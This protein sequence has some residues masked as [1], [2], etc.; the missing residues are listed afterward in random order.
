MQG[1]IDNIVKPILDALIP[2]IYMDD[3]QVERVWA[4]KFE[5]DRPIPLLIAEN[6]TAALSSILDAEP[7]ALYI[8]ID[9]DVSLGT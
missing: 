2:F 3:S 6:P 1:D 7:P 4:Q 9:N 8:R 5:P